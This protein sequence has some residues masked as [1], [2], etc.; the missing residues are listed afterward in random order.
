M[1]RNQITVSIKRKYRRNA[2]SADFVYGSTI[3]YINCELWM[4]NIGSASKRRGEAERRRMAVLLAERFCLST[5]KWLAMFPN[6]MLLFKY[7]EDFL[8]D[9][10]TIRFYI[11]SMFFSLPMK[12]ALM[13]SLRF[14]FIL[15]CRRYH[16]VW[17]TVWQAIFYLSF[18]NPAVFQNAT[19]FN[20]QSSHNNCAENKDSGWRRRNAKQWI[21]QLRKQ[22]ETLP[23]SDHSATKN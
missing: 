12:F 10:E 11:D 8:C 14:Q 3:N 5:M 22:I 6:R 7:L 13:R 20:L 16:L 17:F 9:S 18:G 21:Q 4:N 1:G 23:L 19:Q 15:D 2:P